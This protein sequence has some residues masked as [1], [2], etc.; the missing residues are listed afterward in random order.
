MSESE[1]PVP[2]MADLAEK[3]PK[4]LSSKAKSRAIVADML[5]DKLKEEKEKKEKQVEKAEVTEVLDES[6][7][8]VDKD[9]PSLSSILN[10]KDP[11]LE[12]LNTVVQ[13]IKN[14][15]DLAPVY[16]QI[17]RLINNQEERATLVNNLSL[18][19]EYERKIEYMK[20]RWAL[21]R[22]MFQLIATGKLKPHECMAF[23]RL[24]QEEEKVI[25][26]T[27]KAGGTSP[28]DIMTMLNKVDFTF[29]MKQEELENKFKNTTPQGRE[30]VRR[31]S[32]KLLKASQAKNKSKD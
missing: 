32:Y 14:G 28:N 16:T 25:D 8:V 18:T 15:T 21:E 20:A 31:L 13:G 23:M 7:N 6:C 4:I 1:N 10:E 11:T 12:V 2:P 30:I 22:Y 17:A 5:K 26:S 29:Q 24:I 9:L 27:V 19:H 3:P